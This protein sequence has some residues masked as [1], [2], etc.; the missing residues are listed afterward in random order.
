MG[1]GAFTAQSGHGTFDFVVVA[2]NVLDPADK[3]QWKLRFTEASRALYEATEG[4]MSFGRIFFGDNDYGLGHAEFVLNPGKGTAYATL[5]G[6]GKIAHIIQLYEQQFEGE[7]RAIVH[8]FGHQAFRLGDEYTGEI[9]HDDIAATSVAVHN[10]YPTIPL[11][12]S[13]LDSQSLQYGYAILLFGTVLE[14]LIVFGPDGA[15]GHT[16][17]LLTV[18]GGN[19]GFNKD[20]HTAV[21]KR[22]RYQPQYYNH[23]PQNPEGIGI[24]CAN[25][26]NSNYCLM[27]DH[28]KDG[29]SE[30]CS[31]SNH[32]LAKVTSHSALYGG[33]SCWEV[34]QQQMLDRYKFALSVPDPAQ[35]GQVTTQGPVFEDLVKEARIALVMDRSGSMK[36]N[37]KID[38]VRFGLEQWIRSAPTLNERLSVIWFNEE[39]E[40]LLPLFQFEGA[41]DIAPIIDE[42]TQV[43]PAGWTNIRDG[44]LEGIK[45]IQSPG[46]RSAVQAIVL[47]T[48][49]IHN[50]PVGSQMRE[51]IPEL[52]AAG[53]PVFVLAIGPPGTVDY[54]ALEELARETGG[55]MFK[56]DD[57]AEANAKIVLD[58]PKMNK[59]L[60]SG[61]ILSGHQDIAVAPPESDF[62]KAL[63]Q[64]Q[65]DRLPLN[66]VA[67]L[68]GLRGIRAMTASRPRRPDAFFSVPFLVEA[69]A[70]LTQFSMTFAEDAA[71]HLHLVDPQGHVVS[72]D[73]QDTVLIAPQRPFA[74]AIVR[75]PKPGQWHAV[76]VRG[77]NGPSTR[78]Y[79]SAGVHN[80]RIVVHGDCDR[81]VDI[82]QPARI[83]AG[84]VWGD[85][86]SGLQVSAHLT[87]PDGSS[88]ALDLDDETDAEP[89]SGDY[90]AHLTPQV[91]GR[92]E[93]EIRITSRGRGVRH[94]GA[95]HRASHGPHD[96]GHAQVDL[97][98]QAP[99]FTRSIPIYFDS[100]ERRPAED[101]EEGSSLSTVAQ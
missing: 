87:G 72:F 85:R 53:I 100:G 76:I 1:T 48:D 15:L 55:A 98:S 59:A 101:I 40:T 65:G 75:S 60:R 78:L 77:S 84:A 9:V 12:D 35:V 89:G 51:A 93:G 29:V 97:R 39:V 52:I 25:V 57:P 82:G 69:G 49:G 17:T 70:T 10:S 81:R 64:A 27:D 86:L 16:A 24:G 73:G 45:Q 71:F 14:R 43:V 80:R 63:A 90:L 8:E 56:I 4:Q 31:A 61:L 83:F 79:Y 36:Q 22:V 6:Y 37:N 19:A 95:I 11:V 7:A 99:A 54:D 96:N 68:V 41:T 3:D 20:P 26:A 91:P 34:M 23:S 47:L 62:A 28:K 46:G 94:A 38:G 44:L 33:V 13:I 42:A 5:G 88:H 58:I 50:R 32:D 66:E 21:G 92:Y 2:R 67:Q 18:G 30:F 74:T